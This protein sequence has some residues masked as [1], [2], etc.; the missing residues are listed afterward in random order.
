VVQV[1][2]LL[3]LPLQSRPST[4]WI[5]TPVQSYLV[6][7]R[8]R[9]ETISP[10]WPWPEIL[11]LSASQV[12]RTVDLSNR[13]TDKNTISNPSLHFQTVFH[14]RKFC[15]TGSKRGTD[16]WPAARNCNSAL[17][18]EQTVRSLKKVLP[19]DKVSIST[20]F[21]S[22]HGFSPAWIVC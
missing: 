21:S 11:L 3:A 22:G 14:S 15:R 4:P 8:W 5:W 7:S 6:I 17:E 12:G 18:C 2:E 20:I 19:N 10:G 16:A 1:F 13:H 9:L